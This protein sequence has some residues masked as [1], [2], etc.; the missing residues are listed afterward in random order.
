MSAN[1]EQEKRDRMYAAMVRHD[2]QEVDFALVHAAHAT[3][4]KII[5]GTGT[6]QEKVS[7]LEA[8]RSICLSLQRAL[9]DGGRVTFEAEWERIKDDPAARPFGGAL[10][11]PTRILQPRERP[12]RQ[13]RPT[14][15]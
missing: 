6:A 7:Q 11:A 2:E 14:D 4:E 8:V 3:Y 1:T 13:R 9:A 10:N 15:E 5:D 12:V